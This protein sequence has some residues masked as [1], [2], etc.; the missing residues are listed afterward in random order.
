[1]RLALLA[2]VACSSGKGRPVED[3]RPPVA[4]GDAPAAAPRD[5]SASASAD[6]AAP[7]LG[8][9]QVR[10]EWKNVPVAARSSP[11]LSTCRTPRAPAVAPT[12]TWG[13]PDALVILEGAPVPAEARVV[14]GACTLTPRIAIGSSLEIESAFDR[15]ASVVVIRRGSL[16]APR[17]L[18]E[19]A[20]TTVQLPI[21]GHAATVP[22]EAGGLYEL[23]T[24]GKQPE[25][26]WV[27]AGPGAVTDAN[28]QVT[29][30]DLAVGEHV[31]TAWLP[32]RAGQPARY[33]QGKVVVAGGEL[34]AI[35]LELA[36]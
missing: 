32:P 26:A 3:A 33:A 14:I 31:V 19:G 21:A 24:G 27:V 28:G 6:A 16:A 8:D 23:S 29:V 4:R 25:T 13:I 1:M 20:P 15:P 9:V 36:E 10:V 12:T 30:H 11:G 5:A 2:L 35:T 22:L 34:A 7:K 17:E 18:S